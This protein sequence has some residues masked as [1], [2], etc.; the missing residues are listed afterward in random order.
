MKHWPLTGRKIARNSWNGLIFCLEICY[1]AE[2]KSVPSSLN[3]F[4]FNQCF[5]A[6]EK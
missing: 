4:I 6:F 5:L 2:K 1:Y 3:A